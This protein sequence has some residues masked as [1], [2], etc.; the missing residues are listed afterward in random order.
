MLLSEDYEKP[1][2]QRLGYYSIEKNLTT[3]PNKRT[4]E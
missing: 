3:R 2:D 1:Q 4:V